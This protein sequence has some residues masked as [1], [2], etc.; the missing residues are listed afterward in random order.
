MTSIAGA[1]QSKCMSDERKGFVDHIEKYLG[2]IQRGWKTSPD[3][4]PID[5]SVIECM[6]GQIAQARVFSTLGLSDFPLRSAV[7][8]KII[9]HE[10]F[11]AVPESFGERNIPA[12]LQQLGLNALKN[13]YAYLAG[14]VIERGN[15]IFSGKPFYAFYTAIPVIL[16]EAFRGYT[17]DDGDEMVFAWMVPITNLEAAFVRTRGWGIFEQLLEARNADLVDLD[18]PDYTQIAAKN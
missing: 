2:R 11:I 12:L 1:I 14:E 18:R 9:R 7:S 3:G 13:H 17:F 15:P 10:L 8:D 5:F 6:G 16:P 4:E